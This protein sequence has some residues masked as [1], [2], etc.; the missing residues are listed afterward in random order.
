MDRGKIMNVLVFTSQIMAIE[1][2]KIA[3]RKPLYFKYS[4]IIPYTFN[5]HIVYLEMYV[6]Y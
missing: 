4:P 6:I 3:S 5:I 1:M 2:I